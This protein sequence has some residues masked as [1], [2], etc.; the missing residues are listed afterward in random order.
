MNIMEWIELMFRQYGYFV[1]LVGIPID[2]I[3]L[4]LPPGQTTLTYTGYLTFKGVLNWLPALLLAYAG[5]VIGITITYLIGY[6]VG[7]PLLERYGKWIFIKPKQI[8]KTKKIYKK[9]GNCMLLISFFIPGVRQFF[10]YFVGIIR[11][12]F[13]SFALYAYTGAAIWVVF[14]IG[15]GYVFGEQ[16]QYIFRMI[17]QY[18]KY[19]CI[20]AGCLAIILFV[21]KW[22]RSRMRVSGER[23][24]ELIKTRQPSRGR[25][26]IH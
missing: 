11:L 13:R 8:E 25:G 6:R 21:W 2:F 17:E 10:G 15:V 5:S 4:P 7:A 3:A 18:L 26:N 1:L 12:P 9:Y 19:I 16:W 14:F 20:G 24:A 22:R 23:G